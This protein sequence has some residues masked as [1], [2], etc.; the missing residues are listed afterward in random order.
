MLIGVPAE[1]M[2]GEARVA[3][4]PE[5]AKKLIGQGHVVRVQAGA[6][7]LASVPDA[8]Y[9]AVGAEVVDGASAW[10][11]DLVLKVRAPEASETPHI[12][13]GST[14]VG[15]LEPFNAEGLQRIAGAGATVFALEAAP[16]TT[17][18]QSMY[19]LSSQANIARQIPTFLPHAN[20]GS[21]HSQSRTRGHSRCRCCRLA[22][23]RHGQ[24]LGCGD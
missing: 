7:V 3:V 9:A 20:D 10:G 11:C 22:G 2:A 6:G 24:A 12:K 5:T 14:V 23:Y 15:M 13:S 1:T 17:R 16:R 19:V 8:A 18:A 4:T 21:G